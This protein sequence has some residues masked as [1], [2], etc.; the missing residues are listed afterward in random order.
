VKVTLIAKTEIACDDQAQC[1]E[2]EEWMTT[3]YQNHRS[4]EPADHLAEFAGRSC[5]QSFDRPN[6]KTAANVDYLANILR[7]QHFSVLEHASATFYVEGASRSLT[8]ELVR[9]R[10]LSFSQLSQRYVDGGEAGV[11][12]PP[13]LLETSDIRKSVRHIVEDIHDRT[14][15]AY[16]AVRQIL[17]DNGVTGKR[18]KE[19]ARAFLTNMTETKI[20]VTGNHRAWREFLT[21]RLSVAADVEIRGLATEILRKLYEIAPNTYQD[22]K[23]VLESNVAVEALPSA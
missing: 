2:T 7:Q 17:E 4:V 8:H 19:A 3:E 16:Q 5:Y 22:F 13:A 18:A 11:V 21:K 6:P 10:H 15:D 23:P 1:W 20:V 14:T 12:V 9:H